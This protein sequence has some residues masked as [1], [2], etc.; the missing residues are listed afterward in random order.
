MP[1]LSPSLDRL[2]DA[3]KRLPGLGPRSA[4]RIAQYLLAD[5][6]VHAL[7]LAHALEE[8]VKNVKRCELCNTLTDNRLCPICAD[9]SRDKTKICIVE[10]PADQQAL[11]E[12]MAYRGRYFVL[13]GLLSPV[14][15]IG[16]EQLH[17]PKLLSRVQ[18][19]RDLKEIL[20][21]TPF[22]P[23]GDATAHFIAKAVVAR[24]QDIRVSRLARGIP[25][26]V[27]LEYTDANTI[28]SAIFG[29]R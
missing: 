28:A 22:T 24:R 2:I 5:E 4:A 21:A 16:A 29:R 12:T 7:S 26:G 1:T 13:M 19:D 6:K 27:E 8:A 10:S 11:E 14:Q 25:A 3:L 23:E 18:E 9:D 15:G 17:L 20:I